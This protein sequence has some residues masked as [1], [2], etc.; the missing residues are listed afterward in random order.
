LTLVGLGVDELSVVP[1]ALG[2]V[3]AALAAATHA[4]LRALAQ[5]ATTE[6]RGAQAVRERARALAPALV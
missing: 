1:P 2:E 3:K 5:W 6:A 4:D